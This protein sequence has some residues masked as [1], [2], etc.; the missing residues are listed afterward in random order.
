MGGDDGRIEV[1]GKGVLVR[2]VGGLVQM[3]NGVLE[4]RGK[5]EEGVK[6]Q[7]GSRT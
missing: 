4:R 3:G 7:C 1:E 5:G 6:G 2:W